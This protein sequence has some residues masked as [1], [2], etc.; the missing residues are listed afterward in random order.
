MTMHAAMVNTHSTKI[1]VTVFPKASTVMV[2]TW[3]SACVYEAG[4]HVP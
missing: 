4:E 3:A 1:F 2:V